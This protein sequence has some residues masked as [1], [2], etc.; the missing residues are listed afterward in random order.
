MKMDDVTD[1]LVAV[2]RLKGCPAQG[3]FDAVGEL[4]NERFRQWEATEAKLPRWER[5]I[6]SQ[7]L[8]Y[9]EG[10]KATVQAN[11]VWR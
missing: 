8:K 1:N 7:V 2:Y 11:A 10:I 6:D 3:A 9:V 5:E 4:L